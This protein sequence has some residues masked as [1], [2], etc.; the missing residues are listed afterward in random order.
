MLAS[1]PSKV[2]C[3]DL[4]TLD[5]TRG[6][7]LRGHEELGLRP[8]SFQMLRCLAERPGEIVSKDELL[9]TVWPGRT[10]TDDSLVQCVKEIRQ[11]LGTDARWIV[12]TVWGRGY[13]FMAKVAPGEV[14]PPAPASLAHT[15][16]SSRTEAASEARPSDAG[17]A[18]DN[19]SER[20][21]NPAQRLG[22]L[23]AVALLTT[24][25]VSASWLVWQR[26]R[27]EPP[28]QLTM[29]AVPALAVLPFEALGTEPVEANE[30]RALAD[31]LA[32]EISRHNW[33]S[34]IALKFTGG[35]R[36]D[37]MDPK[38]I[39]RRLDARYLL[40][41]SLRREGEQRFANAGLVEAETGRQLW[42]RS[43]Q[44]ATPQ[45][46]RYAV[47][48]IASA[49]A[50]NVVTIESQRPLPARLQPGHY[51]LR[52]FALL[53]NQ[54]NAANTKAAQALLEKCLEV[55]RNWAIAW[56]AYSWALVNEFY[57]KD[58]ESLSRAEQAIEHAI[59]L[60]PGNAAAY[61][62]RAVLL[63][64]RGDPHGGIAASQ[65]ALT[66]NPNLPNAHAEL[67]RNKIDVGLAREAIAHLEEAIRLAPA[68]NSV[69]LW[70]WWAGQAALH[71]G[72]YEEAVRW[73]EKA[74]QGNPANTGPL[75]WLAVAYAGLGRENDGRALLAEYA[76][77]TPAFTVSNWIAGRAPR[78]AVVA[79][80]FAPIAQTMRRLDA[81]EGRV[82]IGSGP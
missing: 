44:Y 13:Q 63:R 8:Q 81:G 61:E 36:G 58:P 47:A 19:R 80:Q 14:E 72:E 40:M 34:M 15:D 55:D 3:F 68:H 33:G 46:R 50:G 62:R 75:P 7:V 26:L 38:V 77:K 42:V 9:S 76:A 43:Y 66:L 24:I 69:Y 39:G 51:T 10:V 71:M 25:L 32:T 12:K 48:R 23:I 27:P 4:F 65:H 1:S 73:L 41:G 74:R 18:A 22:G 28:A 54:R 45:D 49:I 17:S 11:A 2:L 16:A 37:A 6:V 60:A 31:S 59:K 78:N 53:S 52:A 79:T 5:L 57:G 64:T 29:M 35:Y 70:W 67:G 21:N 82:K 30:A 20:S 56:V